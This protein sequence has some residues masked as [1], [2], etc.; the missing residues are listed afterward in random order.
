MAEGEQER[1]ELL[2]S[3]IEVHGEDV[4]RKLMDS[5]PPFSWDQVA[6]K[7]DLKALSTA[8]TAKFDQVDAQF[9]AVAAEFVN[10]RGEISKVEGNLF[11][12]IAGLSIKIGELDSKFSTKIGQLDSKIGKLDSSFSKKITEQTRVMVLTMAGFSVTVCGAMAG[13]ILFA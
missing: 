11:K 5:L 10:L 8:I 9:T 1:F 12:E 4:A 2:N 3:L 13:G 6:T 7:D